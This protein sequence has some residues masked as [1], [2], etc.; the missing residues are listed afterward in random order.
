MAFI[1]NNHHGF[2]QAPVRTSTRSDMANIKKANATIPPDFFAEVW[3]F[4]KIRRSPITKLITNHR[5]ASR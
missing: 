3:I 4:E 5:S 2:H 1:K